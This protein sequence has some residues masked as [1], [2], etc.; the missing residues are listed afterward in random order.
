MLLKQAARL[1]EANMT[2]TYKEKSQELASNP[3]PEPY[4]HNSL[5]LT[6]FGDTFASAQNKRPLRSH[7][8]PHLYSGSLV[9]SAPI[10]CR[11]HSVS[12]FAEC[13]MF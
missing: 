4:S 7:Q 10:S 2:Q 8:H 3:T 9:I 11:I 13:P 5:I 12:A 6:K 1:K